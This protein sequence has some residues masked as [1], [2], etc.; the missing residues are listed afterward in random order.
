MFERPLTLRAEMD[1]RATRPKADGDQVTH[2][3]KVAKVTARWV[4][5]ARGVGEQ[6]QWVN[7]I[8]GAEII[9]VSPPLGF[10]RLVN[11]AVAELR[12]D[13]LNHTLERLGGTN[14]LRGAPLAPMQIKSMFC[15]SA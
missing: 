6:G 12:A 10:L 9:N 1:D 13:D 11:R 5:E 4:P 3:A 2:V 15:S 14:G 7:K 8:A